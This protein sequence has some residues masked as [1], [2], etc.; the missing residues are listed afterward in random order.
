[1]LSRISFMRCTAAMRMPNVLCSE[2]EGRI[3]MLKHGML[4]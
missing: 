4:S 1:M 2:S 3:W